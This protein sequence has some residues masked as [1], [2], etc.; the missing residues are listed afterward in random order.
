LALHEAINE[1][2]AAHQ[3]RVSGGVDRRVGHQATRICIAIGWVLGALS[4]LAWAQLSSDDIAALQ[5]RAQVEGWTFTMGENPATGRSLDELCGLVEPEDWR[6][7]ATFDPCTPLRS[8]P[9]SY[10]WRALGGCTPVRNQDGCGSCWAFATVGPLECNILIKTGV[11]E[12]LSEQWLVSCNSDNWGCNG[13]WWAHDYHRS[14]KDPCGST[15]AVRESSFPYV[16]SD[17]PCNCP[18]PHIYKISSWA[19]IG[20]AYGVPSVSAI[21]QAILDYGPVS[22]AVYV[23]SAFQAYNGGVFN[24]CSEGTVNHGVVLVGWDD[25]QGSNGVWFMR[26]SWSAG[27][28]EGGYMRIEYGCSRIGYAASYVDYYPPDCNTNGIP[29]ANEIAAD[30]SLDCQPDGVLDECQLADNDC[31]SNQIPDSCDAAQ[32]ITMHPEDQ[33]PC[34]SGQ[35]VFTVAAPYATGYQWHK[36]GVPISGATTDSLIIYGASP[37]DEDTYSCVV[38][39]GCLEAF[40]ESAALTLTEVP[41]AAPLDDLVKCEGQRA[42]FV[43]EFAGTEPISY[44]WERDG[45]PIDG[46]SSSSYTIQ[47]VGEADEG[48]YRCQAVNVCG[49]AYTNEAT[50]VVDP[51]P[52]ITTHPE[53]TCAEI[54]GTAVFSVGAAGDGPFWYKWYKDDT[55][56]FQG[57]GEDTLI[58]EDVQPTDAGGYR[59]TVQLIAAPTCQPSSDTAILL[60]GD[61]LVCTYDLAGDMTGDDD[62]DLEDF[63]LFQACF[64]TGMGLVPGCECANLDGSDDD[65]NLSDFALWELAC[66]G[67]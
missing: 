20:S 50:L 67:T 39:Q 57:Q 35:A 26:N 33:K 51:A 60:V 65:I 66:G 47:S 12:D 14:K 63:S 19:Y 54:G 55:F 53:D 29:D 22:V 7:G 28:G 24:D 64:G 11:E 38:T 4:N 59:A 40:S 36:H 32:I 37:D 5:A 44:Q 15:G 46:A 62:V 49:S 48:M 13:G 21:K 27:W 17:A 34:P 25:N 45:V 2:C 10:D 30:P 43:A 1:G 9:A 23:D 52:I 42:T 18:Y 31:N 56:V 61:C 8:L 58:V 6:V 41:A 16:A 3:R